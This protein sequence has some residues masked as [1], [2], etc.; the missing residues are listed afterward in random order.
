MQSLLNKAMD[1]AQTI[2]VKRDDGLS[3]VLCKFPAH[4][5]G[6]TYQYLN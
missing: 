4:I 1:E 6:D 5:V 3:E 2:T